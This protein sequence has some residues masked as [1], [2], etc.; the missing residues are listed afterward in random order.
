MSEY[1]RV[2]FGTEI[3]LMSVIFKVTA[4][5]CLDYGNRKLLYIQGLTTVGSACCG[6]VECRVIH[7][8]GF[9]VS[10]HCKIDYASGNPL[11]KVEP[12]TDP[13][14]LEDVKYLL[15]KTFPSSLFLFSGL[16]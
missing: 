13:S 5:G 1:I 9:V 6:M 16:A 11:S 12:V 14:T 3:I 8:P 4:E 2:A 15:I 10:W 7:V